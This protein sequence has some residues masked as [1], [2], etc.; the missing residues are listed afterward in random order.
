LKVNIENLTTCGV[1]FDSVSFVF[2]LVYGSFELP[3][4]NNS[5][6]TV[7]RELDELKEFVKD[8]ESFAVMPLKLPNFFQSKKF[9]SKKL[10]RSIEFPILF[11][12]IS[13]S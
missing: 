3:T 11:R 9:S 13:N 7:E 2:K 5:V 10:T 6:S 1:P 4:T 12:K 8:F